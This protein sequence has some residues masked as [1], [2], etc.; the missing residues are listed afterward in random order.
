MQPCITTTLKSDIMKKSTHIQKSKPISQSH[1]GSVIY[2][3]FRNILFTIAVIAFL[4][5]S[6]L[7]QNFRIV[8]SGPSVANPGDIITYVVAIKN[9][10][11]TISDLVITDH[12]PSNSLCTYLKSTPAGVYDSKSNTITWDKTNNPD[13]TSF[14]NKEI[15]LVVSIRVGIL[16]SGKYAVPEK[17]T[18]LRS[19]TILNSSFIRNTVE[20]NTIET[21]IPIDG[22]AKLPVE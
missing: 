12:L 5:S 18:K 14:A 11:N 7:A 13:M 2:K 21:I 20:S 17:L 9:N 8:K 10:G 1:S 6:A 19:H 22:G 15:F 3:T 16:N 4:T